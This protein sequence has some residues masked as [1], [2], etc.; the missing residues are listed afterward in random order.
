MSTLTFRRTFISFIF[1]LLLVSQ[2]ALAQTTAFT[3]QGKLSDNSTPASG[4]YDFQ[5]K[6]FDTPTVGTG[7]QV[8]S[9]LTIPNVTVTNSL[10]TVRVDFGAC[11]NCFNGANRFLEIAVKPTSGGT[12]TTLGPRQP[13][14]ST[15]YAMRSLKAALADGLSVACVNCVTS[16]Q[17]QSV[18]GSAVSGTIPV[19]SVPAGSANYIQNTTTQQASNFNISGNGTAAGTL[20]GNVVNATLQYN[21]SGSRVLSNAGTFNLFAGINAGNANTGGSNSFFGSGAEI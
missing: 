20:S 5:F 15:P 1:I 3:Y 14:T 4:Q 21:L 18:N 12:F 17:I 6:L 9:I 16:S 13:I 8:G 2:T 10:F 19:A 7:T 11:A